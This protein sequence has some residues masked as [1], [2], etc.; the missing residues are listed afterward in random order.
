MCTAEEVRDSGLSN[1]ATFF[2]SPVDP[3]VA[4]SYAVLPEHLSE[5]DE[6]CH[7]ERTREWRTMF[8][9]GPM[10]QEGL[11]DKG[12]FCT[13]GGMLSVRAETRMQGEVVA[14]LALVYR[15]P[16]LDPRALYNNSIA[17]D[18]VFTIFCPVNQ[19]NVPARASTLL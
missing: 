4:D 11:Q 18:S 5:I 12:I 1:D 19:L 6:A 10:R 14:L 8:E 16:P 9:V 13:E 7:R 2:P 17:T 15:N 3:G